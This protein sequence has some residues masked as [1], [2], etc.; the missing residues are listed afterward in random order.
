MSELVLRTR[1]RHSVTSIVV[2]HDMHSARKVADRL[3]MLFP[4]SRLER[5]AEQVVYDGPPGEIDRA[6]DQRVT[7]FVRG[8][9]RERLQEMQQEGEGDRW[10]NG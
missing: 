4:L 2:T 5:Q 10:T 9:A 1:R 7:Q 3:V 8:E 6:E